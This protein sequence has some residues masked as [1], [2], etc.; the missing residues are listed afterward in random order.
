MRLIILGFVMV[1]L[2]GCATIP[3][4]IGDSNLVAKEQILL[5]PP[6]RSATS[7]E[8]GAKVIIVRDSGF[9]GA[10]VKKRVFIDGV[11]VVELWPA[12]RYEAFLIEG[13]RIFGVIPS[14]NLFGTHGISETTVF[15][16]KGDTCYLRIYT[17]A[18]MTTRIQKS[19][20]IK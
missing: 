16:R 19:A 3:V 9:T 11:P 1:C 12:E 4:R 7:L 20:L 10:G 6:P 18:A 5:L 2:F 15:L 13:D 8:D 14:P 17:D